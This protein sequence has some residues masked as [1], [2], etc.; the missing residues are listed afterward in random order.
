M[1]KIAEAIKLVITSPDVFVAGFG[2]F[3]FA[4]QILVG[5]FKQNWL[6]P[7]TGA[8]YFGKKRGMI[9]TGIYGFILF[10]SPFVFVFF[11]IQSYYFQFLIGIT[12]IY[13]IYGT[14]YWVIKG[15]K[16]Y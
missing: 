4:A 9:S 2:L 11:N 16:F 3:I 7:L 8:E 12:V 5:G 1:D 14:I 15:A 13:T 6:M 10:L